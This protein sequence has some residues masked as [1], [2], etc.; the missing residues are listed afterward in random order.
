VYSY[1]AVEGEIN[2]THLR[3]IVKPHRLHWLMF[4]N[5]GLLNRVQPSEK[6][7]VLA[8]FWGC[9]KT[10]RCGDKIEQWLFWM[11]VTIESCRHLVADAL[12]GKV[13]TKGDST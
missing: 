1:Y 4:G 11:A 6:Q 9:P 7:C 10:I 2:P 3:T 5:A 12:K 8:G 13:I